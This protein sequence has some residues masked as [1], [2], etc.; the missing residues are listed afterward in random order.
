MYNATM[1]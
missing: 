1:S